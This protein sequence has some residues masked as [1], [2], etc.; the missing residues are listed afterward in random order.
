MAH[1]LHHSHNVTVFM[2]CSQQFYTLAN[3]WRGLKS[4]RLSLPQSAFLEDLGVYAICIPGPVQYSFITCHL[5]Y[6]Y[7]LCFYVSPELDLGL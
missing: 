5:L 6:F 3:K 1:N 7:H 2:C 4:T